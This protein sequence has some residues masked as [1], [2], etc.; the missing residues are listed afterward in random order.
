MEK[1][2]PVTKKPLAR[3]LIVDDHPNTALTLAR[4][5]S[6]LGQGIE[7]VTAN[8]G[9]LALELVRDRTVDLLITDM[10]MNGM[11]G[12]ELIEKMQSHP[13]GRPSFTALIT[14]YDVPGL[15]MS[16]QRL[17]VNEVLI[18]P[19]R[20]ERICQIVSKAVEDLG[21]SSVEPSETDTKP[22]LK[23]LV[24]DDVPDNVALLTRYLENEGYISI[25][26][27]NGLEALAK[28][29][30]EI[31]DLV[32]LDVN[33][34]E[35]DGFETLQEIR[36][37]LALSHIPVIILTAARLEPMDMQSALNMGADDYVTKPFDRRELLA[38]IRT[39]LRVKE[40]EDV[41][42]RRNKELNLLPE[43]GRELSART[44]VGELAEVVLRR[45]VETLGALLGHFMVLT[46]TGVLFKTFR[47]SAPSSMQ[48]D[49][50]PTPLTALLDQV[51][52]TR[53]GFIIRDTDIDSRWPVMLED[54][55]RS[56][57]IVP[58][59]GRFGVLGILVLA[60]EQVDY[61]SL[62]HKLLL[63][64]I[65]SQ[66][67]IAV[68]NAQLYVS[69]EQE[70]QRLDA[71]LQS[72]EDAFLMFDAGLCLS[73]VNHAGQRLFTDYEIRLG[74]PLKPGCGYDE[75]LAL[76]QQAQQEHSSQAREI[77]W[78][79]KRVFAGRVIPI[80]DSYVAS[81]HDISHFKNLERVK[82]E[83][84][85]AA[86][87][88]LR[89]PITSIK[90]FS[91]L[92]FQA[93]PLNETQQEFAQR[94]QSGAESMEKLVQDLL[95]TTKWEL[96][97]ELKIEVVDLAS[98]LEKVDYVFRPQ[99]DAK[100]QQ[101]QFQIPGQQVAVRGDETKLMLALGNL[102]SNA[103]KYTPENGY[104]SVS[105]EMGTDVAAVSVR[106]TGCGIPAA[107]LPFIFDRFY[108]VRN[109]D[110]EGVDGNGLGLAIVKSIA[111][112][113]GGQ[114]GVETEAGKGSCFR[115]SLPVLK[116]ADIPAAAV[117]VQGLGD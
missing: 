39:R 15:K 51:K 84:I 16:A 54:P 79:D 6:Q 113:H 71:V 20:P 42:R 12:M 41:I 24:A 81:L 110:T 55:I 22:R 4:A 64:A 90:G 14:A 61:F 102:V 74:Q 73:L 65:A 58:L 85:A 95:E 52:D 40:A 43:I 49:S 31:P 2:T 101:F 107:D 33:M 100:K 19:I 38:R 7:I 78:A 8:S 18:K 53:E 3:I 9:E 114:V 70:R 94:I 99:A 115:I 62:E 34:P 68:E 108:R 75:I 47:F 56:A 25:S 37:D 66:A 26:A 111:E 35:K 88:D 91:N 13:G 11:S 77:V 105:L 72:S 93:G 87:H 29:R 10:V 44:D 32:L 36:T 76:L 63:Q 60:H 104:I 106:D 48:M 1:T 21:K 98:L 96:G 46:P 27:S 57:V 5:I 97:E 80:D 59:L 92:L 28:A 23:I 117:P 89:N 103:I 112:Q 67:A 17:H 83:F 82:N 109:Q 69:M 45:T 30:A 116:T 50:R 86:S